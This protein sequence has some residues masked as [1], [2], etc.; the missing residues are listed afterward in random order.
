MLYGAAVLWS[1]RQQRT[2]ALSTAEAEANSLIELGKDIV[3]LRRLLA[4]L[5]S[6]V[7]HPTPALEDSKSAIK[8]T[9]AAASWAKTRH[10]DTAIHKLREWIAHGIM[11]IEYCSTTAMLADVFT[12]ALPAETHHRFKTAILGEAYKPRYVFHRRTAPAA[13]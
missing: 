8:W 3:W 11:R 4:D 9:T 1:S 12:K 10:V 6:P 13:A 7:M 5:G 2:V